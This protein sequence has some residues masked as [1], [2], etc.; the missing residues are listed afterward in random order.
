MNTDPALFREATPY[1]HVVI[2]DLC[3]GPVL[4]AAMGGFDQARFAV[5][6]GDHE[7]GKSQADPPPCSLMLFRWMKTLKPRLEEWTGI[8][9]LEMD[10]TGGGLHRTCHGGKLDMHVDFN[11]LPDGRYRRLNGLLF[12]N[13][14]YTGMDFGDLYLGEECKECGGDGEIPHPDG[15]FSYTCTECEG[16]GYGVAIEPLWNRLVVFETNETTWHGHPDPWQSKDYCRLSFAAYWYTHTPP[17][18]IIE[19]HFSTIWA[20]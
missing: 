17:E 8:Q 19:D 6:D 18:G 20:P 16:C 7:H 4:E 15:W 9:G 13:K 2:D 1:P 12:A 3:P 10:L 5:F 14:R 11:R